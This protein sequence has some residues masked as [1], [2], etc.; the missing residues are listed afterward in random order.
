VISNLDAIIVGGGHNGLTAAAYLASAGKQVMVLER[1]Y[2]LGGAAVTEEFHPG[3]RN[4]MCSY[5]ASLLHP[6]VVNDLELHRHGLTY[7]PITHSFH[8]KPD[9]RYLLLTGND[10]RDRAE[11]EKFSSNDWEGMAAFH[12]VIEHASNLI[13]P[14]LL[15]PP[16]A[17]IGGRMGIGDLLN[18]GKLGL[19]YRRLP[20]EMR[21]RVLQLFTSS[22]REIVER[23]IESDEI[24]M[25]YYLDS[26]AGSMMGL[27]QAGSAINLLHL[28]IGEIDG[29]RGAWALARG[30]MGSI[31]DAIASSAREHGAELRTDSPVTRILAEDGRAIGVEIE[32]GETIHARCVVS[33]CE[34]K[35]TFLKLLD[36]HVLDDGF[37]ADIARW[38]T[39]SGTFRMNLALE[40]LP[41]FTCLPGVQQ[42]N[43]HEGFIALKPSTEAIDRAWLQARAGEWPDEPLLTLIIPSVKD[44]TLAPPGQHVMTV[45]CQHY[46]YRLSG[47]RS[48]DDCK[49]QAA[50][51]VVATIGKYAPNVPDA[52]IGRNVLSPL[53]L[54]RE[55]GLTGGDVYHGKMELDQIF[56]MRPHP[57]CSGYR[58]PV[59]RLYLCA[60]GTHPGGGV[61][62]APGHNSAKVVLK[63]LR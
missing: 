33:A 3:Y 23:Y 26:T 41:D 43:H 5:V 61:S 22:V 14:L 29:R 4:S 55:Y 40:V 59:N 18:A 12:K 51:E 34:P 28:H 45:F 48:W 11:V 57:K 27:D 16:P 25:I 17:L 63:D 31:S 60:S 50:D 47:G 32:G 20:A 39:E 10:E 13:R 37:R 38:R 52:V 58:T 19:A 56:A 42:A 36:P 21:Y 9:G 62:G 54:E 49:E 30:G 7:Y 15:A 1:R 35:A 8:P 6:Q 46:P 24:R 53:D 2:I 44:D